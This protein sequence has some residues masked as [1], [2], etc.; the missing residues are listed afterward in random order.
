MRWS[1][2]DRVSRAVWWKALR[3]PA[4]AERAVDLDELAQFR[5]LRVGE[6]QLRGEQ[7]RVGVQ[8]FEVARR[9]ALVA[10]VGEAAR[11]LRG[12][13]QQLLLLAEFPALLIPGQRIGHFAKR[14]LH[15]LP[16]YELGFLAARFCEL[17]LRSQ[18]AGG[19]HRLDRAERQRPERRR[20]RNQSGEGTALESA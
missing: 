3:L 11:V 5:Q 19:E 13:P 16:I 17:D 12:R 18:P 1:E 7:P 8:H 15:G 20:S 10:H 2:N 14:L 6:R 9:A 4:A